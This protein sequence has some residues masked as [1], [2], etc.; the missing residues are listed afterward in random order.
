MKHLGL[1]E[2]IG[3][4]SLAARWAGWETVAWVEWNEY[5]QNQLRKNFP[6]AKGYGDI[7]KTDFRNYAGKIDILTGG[8]PCQPASLAGKRKGEEDDRWLWPEAIRVFG[9]VRPRYAVFENPDDLLTLDNGEPFERICSSLEDYGYKVETYGIPA[10][11]VGAWHERDR[12]WI[13]AYANNLH[14]KG[15]LADRENSS[16]AKRDKGT[17][18]SEGQELDRERLWLESGSEA[19]TVPNINAPGLQE[20]T[21]GQ[22]SGFF[23]TNGASKGCESSGAFTEIGGYWQ[24]E[25]GVGR[26]VHGVPNRVDR[27]KALGNSIVP[28]IAHEIFKAI[29]QYEKTTP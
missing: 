29:N 15:G 3:G 6:E 18:G 2:G 13:I 12:I 7:T 21:R 8:P 22:F 9:E 23:E 28:Q 19:K 20:P 25:P 10:A 14:D 26:M 17:N 24:A 27:I 16:Q 4:F 5:C 1:F 11:C